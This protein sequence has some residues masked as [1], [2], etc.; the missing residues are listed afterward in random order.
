MDMQSY[1]YDEVTDCARVIEVIE[2][3]LLRKGDG[4]AVSPIR[5]VKQYWSLD[6]RLLAEVDPYRMINGGGG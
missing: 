4:T 5:I 1:R 6:G 2:T 3:T